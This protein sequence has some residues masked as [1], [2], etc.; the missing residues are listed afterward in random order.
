MK[1]VLII[2]TALTM[3]ITAPSV[4]AQGFLGKL[5]GGGKEKAGAME[6]D[7]IKDSTSNVLESKTPKSDSRNMG[8]VYYAKFPIRVG[9]DNKYTYSKKVL[10]ELNESSGDITLATRRTFEGEKDVQHLLYS[11]KPGTP[12]YFPITNSKKLGHYLIDG[13][14]HNSYGQLG[15]EYY[16]MET[17][18][19]DFNQSTGSEAVSSGWNFNYPYILELE[20][21]IIVIA[22]LDYIV[23]ANTPA[24]YKVLQE[25]GSYNLF[26]KKDKAEKAKAMTDAQVWDKCKVFFDKYMDAYRKAEDEMNSLP[27]PIAAF[28]EQPSN[29]DFVAATKKR[30]E[31]MPYY[32]NRQ[33]VYVYSVTAWEYM[34]EYVGLLGKTLTY[35]QTQIIAVFRNGDKCEYARLLIRQDNTYQGGT[36]IENWAGNKVYCS[37]DQQLED[38]KCEKAMI[39]KK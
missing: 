23:D 38:I 13:I 10:I 5:G 21:G 27:K 29:A 9:K 35:R 16:A 15:S 2:T 1:K 28:K 12:D 37:G 6:K 34:Y 8:G 26:Y 3:G 11:P 17:N 22:Q 14:K 39:Y 30:M 19:L 32:K 24:K 25:K 7:L 31:E 20:P 33:L 18:V 4:Q 36:S